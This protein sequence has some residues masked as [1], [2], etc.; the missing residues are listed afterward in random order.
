MDRSTPYVKDYQH[1]T[2]IDRFFQYD[3]AKKTMTFIGQSLELRIPKRFEV[4]GL[5]NVTDTVQTLAVM[6]MIIDDT[7]Q[8]AMHLLTVITMGVSETSQMTVNGVTYLV[9]RLTAGDAFITQTQ[10]VQDKSTVGA[11]YTEFIDRGN[12][13]YWF[14]YAQLMKLFDQANTVAGAGM[15]VDPVIFEV[16]YSHLARDPKDLYRPF[17]YGQDP[18]K[19]FVFVGLRSVELAT[20]STTAR[21][22]GSYFSDGLNASL[23]HRVTERQPFEDLLRGLPPTAAVT[24][25]PKRRQ[26]TEAWLTVNGR[27]QRSRVEVFALGPNN[28]L[29]AHLNGTEYPLLPGGGVDQGESVDQA[30]ARE[31]MEEAGWLAD[32]FHAVNPAGLWV[33]RGAAPVSNGW[34]DELCLGSI[35]RAVA[36]SPTAEYGAHGDGDDFSLISINTVMEL[37]RKT[38]AAQT[39]PP[40]FQMHAQFRLAVLETLATRRV[41]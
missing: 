25:A 22:L 10:V 40:R 1:I 5:L 21:L 26:R 39:L 23:T 14:T 17:R 3:A 15:W 32:G 33:Y 12:L 27:V 37:T 13:P 16:I 4:Y 18:E 35:C 2:D 24:T 30:A 31:L 28:T 6:D 11:I 7:Y 8:S 19:S 9:V 38:V 36:F 34:Q 20:S 41:A 29:L